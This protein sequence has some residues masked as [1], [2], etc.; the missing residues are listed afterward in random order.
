M[1]ILGQF[2]Y[3]FYA[4]GSRACHRAKRFSDL[5]LAF[6]EPIPIRIQLKLEELFE[7]SDLP[8]KVDLVDW[9]K[10]APYMQ[11]AIMKQRIRLDP[12]AYTTTNI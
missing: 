12:I 5:D 4:F 2:P 11:E 1:S 9:H 10:C 8:Y 7:E 3:A 6:F